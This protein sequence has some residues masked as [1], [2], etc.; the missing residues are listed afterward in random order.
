MTGRVFI[1]NSLSEQSAHYFYSSLKDPREPY[2]YSF[3]NCNDLIR[4][5][6]TSSPFDDNFFERRRYRFLK[7]VLAWAWIDSQGN[8]NLEFY[9]HF[10]IRS[11]ISVFSLRRIY[12][13]FWKELYRFNIREKGAFQSRAFSEDDVTLFVVF[14]LKCFLKDLEKYKDMFSIEMHGDVINVINNATYRITFISNYPVHKTELNAA[15]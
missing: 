8:R 14:F 5:L 11:N 7:A 2:P 9:D 15:T 4:F 6:K 10:S 13:E 12:G 3:S 1:H